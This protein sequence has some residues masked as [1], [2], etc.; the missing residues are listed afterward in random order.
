M[1]VGMGVL[2]GSF[3]VGLFLLFMLLHDLKRLNQQ[4]DYKNA[5]HSHFDLYVQSPFSQMRM[6]QHNINQLYETIWQVE[7]KEQKKEKE[8]QALMS[9]ISHDIR[10]P[11][12]SMQGY[13]ELVKQSEDEAEKQKYL[14]IVT[15]RLNTLKAILEDLFMHSRIAD[16]DYV[17][18]KENVDFYALL[19]QVL[20]SYYEEFEA[21]QMTPVLEFEKMPFYVQAN[22]EM[23]IRLLQN[24][25]SNALKYG[26][27]TL[28]ITQEKNCLTFRNGIS[29]GTKIDPENLF[30]R[31][32]RSETTYHQDSTG[33]G[34]AIVK[35]IVQ[36]HGW[37]VQA[38]VENQSLVI[39]LYL[40][41]N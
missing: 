11:L 8:M 27:Q 23:M 32:Y 39:Q 21:K 34:L 20:A 4:L 31:F 2:F 12:T 13:L 35:E 29:D 30:D 28:E 25:I 26:L 16:A 40:L 38:K 14:N 37:Q 19:C 18:D 36:A 1:M 3:I 17:F 9:G 6:L 41:D 10:T 33:L 5:R 15:Y 22:P 24:L 7:A